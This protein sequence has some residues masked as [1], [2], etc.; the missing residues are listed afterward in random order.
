MG[1]GDVI[2]SAIWIF[3]LLSFLMVL[4]S[5]ITDLFRDRDLSG[6]GK[7]IWMLFLVFAPVVGTL[8]YLIVR[9]G[10]MA[11]RSMAQ[12]QAA[13]ADFKSYV[14]KAAGDPDP[15]SQIEKAKV[16]LDAGTINQQEYETLKRK[17][18]A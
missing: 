9:G 5:V 3:F 18:L 12:A 16:L 15:A 4:F 11:Q 1:L 17:A 13:E 8:V 14:Q 6:G 7:A 10:G 2:I